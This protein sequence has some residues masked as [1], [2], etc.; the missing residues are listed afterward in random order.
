MTVLKRNGVE[1]GVWNIQ[2]ANTAS[3]KWSEHAYANAWDV[4][5]FELADGTLIRVL[6]GWD[7][8]RK[9]RNFLREVRGA[10][11]DVFRVTLSPDFNDAHADHFHLDMGP[12]TSCR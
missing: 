6:T 12:T 9:Q 4:G 10:A 11:C 1:M 7:G 3:G 2:I 8:E 5:A